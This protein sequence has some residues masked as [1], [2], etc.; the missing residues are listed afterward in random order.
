MKR[1]LLSLLS[2]VAMATL[3][4]NAQI[5]FDDDFESYT[6]GSL[7]AQSSPIWETW[8]GNVVTEDALVSSL[9]ANSGSN[10]LRLFST[11]ANGGPSD[12]ILPFGGKHEF[13]TFHYEMMMYVVAGSGA[14]FNFQGE[15]M[16]GVQ[17]TY[18]IYFNDGGT[19]LVNNSSNTTGGSG[20]Y[21]Y[22]QWFKYEVDVD[23]TNN[24]WITTLDGDVIAQ[25]ANPVN[26]LASLD[27]YPTFSG[28][29][30]NSHFYVDDV[31][32]TY[33]P[34]MFPDLDLGITGLNVRQFGLTGQTATVSGT[35]RNVGNN[36]INSFDITFTDGTTNMTE[37]YS[38]L[39][40]ATLQEYSFSH[41]AMQTIAEGVNP[42]TATVSNINGGMDDNDVNNSIDV[43]VE[44]I[45][46]HPDKK[47]LVEEAT[48]TWCTW[49]PRGA[50]FMA[51]MNELYPDHFVGV[52]VHNGSNDPMVVP[53]YDAGMTSLP[54]F[55]GFPGVTLE[56]E[57]ITD[58]SNIEV[59]LIPRLQEAPV[60]RLSNVVTDF[61]LNG[62]MEVTVRAEFLEAVSGD[63][64]LN[65]IIIEN[66]VTG[67]GSGYN[68]INAYA[69]GGN[70]P[71]GG[72]E[73]LPNPVPASQMVY[74]EVGRALLGGY[75]GVSGSL[76]M[77][78]SAGETHEYSFS[79]I[80]G[81]DI[82]P[83]NVEVIGVLIRP[84]GTIDNATKTHVEDFETGTGETFRNDLAEVYPSPFATDFN[85]RLALS[86]ATNVDVTV[87][88]AVGAAVATRSFGVLSGNP[89]LQ[90]DMENQAPG[91]YY[92]YIQT[93]DFLIT[94]KVQL[95]K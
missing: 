69:G 36:E 57:M 40:L 13:G 3:T 25:F 82:D 29:Q 59:N 27:L 7:I 33:D 83:A 24:V 81:P 76:P 75:A 30:T 39:N 46:P 63:Y 64:R 38:G 17:W 74:E 52:A 84:N 9:Q 5:V 21:P 89:V 86:T 8:N 71:M 56:R 50:V 20:I 70:G 87:Y 37:P 60:A 54:G 92:V 78:I 77:S 85:I 35:V 19:V 61:N 62:E 31:V 12:V 4:L 80:L 53:E 73:N 2:L 49:C 79:Y 14:Y 51:L 23:L 11:A 55:S 88:N 67:T 95:V 15:V 6:N 90:M 41:P 28:N 72:Y 26:A 34:P 16:T 66:G 10:S 32:Y 42:V 91:I 47:V 94:K 45:T 65:A 48:G 18:Q 43:D 22:D 58:P 68:Q 93:D 1:Q 44:G